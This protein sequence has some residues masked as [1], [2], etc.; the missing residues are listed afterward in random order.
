MAAIQNA[1]SYMKS[2][3]FWYDYAT[4]VSNTTNPMFSG[5]L[6]A[7]EYRNSDYSEYINNKVQDDCP[8]QFFRDT[9]TDRSFLSI[10]SPMISHRWFW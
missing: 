4:M 8:N 2:Y 7:M 1:I 6:N 9:Y 10:A 5:M 3:I